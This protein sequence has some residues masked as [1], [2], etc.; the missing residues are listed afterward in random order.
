MKKILLLMAMLGCMLLMACSGDGQNSASDNNDGLAQKSEGAEGILPDENTADSAD[1]GDG[2]LSTAVLYDDHGIQLV[3]E[4][5]LSVSTNRRC[6]ALHCINSNNVEY[7]VTAEHWLINDS[8]VIGEESWISLDPLSEEYNTHEEITNTLY[9]LGISEI[10]SIQCTVYIRDENYEDVDEKEIAMTFSNPLESS[11]IYDIFMEAKAGRQVLLDDENVTATLLGWGQDPDSNYVRGLVYF[12]NKS[13][14]QIPVKVS[15]MTINGLFFENFDRVN[16]L[17]PGE[18]CYSTCELLISEIE[19]ENITSITDIELMLMTDESQNT[20]TVNYDGGVLY[21][22]TL[23][24][25]GENTSAFETGEILETVGDV[26]ISLI[27]QEIKEHVSSDGGVYENKLAIV[28]DSDE[29]IEVVLID[30]YVDGAALDI[31][32]SEHPE[33]AF[34]ISDKEVAAHAK[35]YATI[36]VSTYEGDVISPEFTF[37]FQIR[38]M[39]G[40]AVISTG[41]EQITI[42]PDIE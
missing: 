16:F 14:G 3:F 9:M 1:D 32:K 18:S 5:S 27:S 40:G 31:W 21:P 20:G 25:K 12:E 26:Q 28:N 13:D 39:A 42:T 37:K 15:G 33:A 23:E 7:I 22:V 30:V 19:S 24:V 6:Y 2:V 8:I 10:E 11:V 38:S 34:F 36:N 41:N 17:A 35:R 29:N 4:A